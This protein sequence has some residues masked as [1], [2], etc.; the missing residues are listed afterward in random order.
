MKHIEGKFKGFKGINLYYQG[1]FPTE[2]TQAVVVM[3]H[4]LGAHSSLFNQ[5]VQYLVSQNYEVYAFD[6]RGHGR[7][8]GQR[9][10]INSWKEYREDL[11]A[12]LQM[13]VR[14]QRPGCPCF[15]WGHSLGGTIVLDYALRYPDKLQGIIVTAPALGKIRISPTKLLIGRMLSRIAPRFSLKLGLKQAA[16]SRNPEFCDALLKDPLRHE[17]GSARLATEFFKA[18]NWILNHTSELRIPLLTLH[19]SADEVTLPEAT[20]AFFQMVTYHDKEYREYEEHYHDL[21]VDIEYQRVFKDFGNWLERHL[22]GAAC[23]PLILWALE[24]AVAKK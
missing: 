1:W 9:G 11:H 2:F 21:Y 14:K 19:G 17:Y 6:L 8:P 4:G 7:S 3:V 18:V 13:V 23:Q 15:L 16:C 24:T 22:E 10:H 5:A 20:R 12:F